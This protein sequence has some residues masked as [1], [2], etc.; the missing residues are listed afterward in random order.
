MGEDENQSEHEDG[1]G[2][3]FVD[4]DINRKGVGTT[5]EIIP[6]FTKVHDKRSPC[7]AKWAQYNASTAR[8]FRRLG[9]AVILVFDT[10]HQATDRDHWVQWLRDKH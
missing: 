2:C 8:N 10:V 4:M 9:D 5:L 1:D 7:V 3:C 6:M